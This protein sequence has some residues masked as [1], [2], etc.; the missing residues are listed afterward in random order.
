MT[1]REN[2]RE[3]VD[4]IPEQELDHALTY[5]SGLCGSD[6]ELDGTALVAIQEARDDYRNGRT[7]SLE[8]YRRT[9]PL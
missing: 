3:L 1:V 4:S 9:R 5:L 2:V 6:D 7:G 8:E